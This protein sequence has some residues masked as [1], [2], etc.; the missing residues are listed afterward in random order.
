MTA[1]SQSRSVENL[2]E[3]LME[4][5]LKLVETNKNLS[6]NIF[7]SLGGVC[8]YTDRHNEIKP[9]INELLLTVLLV[10][11]KVCLRKNAINQL[12]NQSI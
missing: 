3:P 4:H 5:N 2:P 11:V 10:Y 6:S 12:I 1:I 7:I 8:D 9:L